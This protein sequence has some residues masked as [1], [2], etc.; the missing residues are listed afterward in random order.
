MKRSEFEIEERIAVIRGGSY[1]LEVNRISW[2]GRK[3][4]YDIRKWKLGNDGE[5]IPLKG[6]TLSAKE[7]GILRNVL[8]GIELLDE[9]EG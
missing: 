3:P 9:V 1:P 4:T 2:D 5:R 6:I 8:S 7:A